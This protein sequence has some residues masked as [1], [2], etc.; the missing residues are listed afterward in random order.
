MRLRRQHQDD[1][2]GRRESDRPQPH[3]PCHAGVD[4][5]FE[6]MLEVAPQPGRHTRSA[7]RASMRRS[8]STS[9]SAQRRSIV[10]VAGRMVRGRRQASTTLRTGPRST[11]PA[12]LLRGVPRRAH[13]PRRYREGPESVQAAQ[14]RQMLVPGL[15]PHRVVAEILSVQ[16]E[17]AA[18]E[19]H[20]R[21]RNELARGQQAARG[22]EDA[23]LQR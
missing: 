17:L 11:A 2:H 10:V 13:T 7:M 21:R 5:L 1:K 6:Q 20:D 8:A 14:L 18:G 19:V 23:Q 15:G 12:V 9:A 22:A 4:R 16:V 3:E